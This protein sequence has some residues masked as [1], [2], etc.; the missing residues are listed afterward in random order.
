MRGAEPSFGGGL[1]CGSLFYGSCLSGVLV[2][3]LVGSGSSGAGGGVVSI[4][5][6]IQPDMTRT[7]RTKSSTGMSTANC[8]QNPGS[9]IQGAKNAAKYTTATMIEIM[10]M[11]EP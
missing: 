10:K 7:R 6:P 2:V 3:V 9:P 5:Q 8:C 4:V 1:V 11:R